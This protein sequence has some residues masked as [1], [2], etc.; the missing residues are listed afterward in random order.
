MAYVR[1]LVG[2]LSVRDEDFRAVLPGVLERRGVAAAVP[3]SALDAGTAAGRGAP[4]GHPTGTVGLVHHSHLPEGLRR[5]SKAAKPTLAAS[6]EPRAAS[7]EPR[8]ASREPRAASR[9][10][11][12]ASR[13]PR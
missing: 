11:R 5:G 3:A 1:T 8:A 13:E 10:P 6:R 7:R 9:E 4:G 12:A 2:E